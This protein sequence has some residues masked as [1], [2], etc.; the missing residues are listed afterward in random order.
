MRAA[1]FDPKK[2]GHYKRRCHDLIIEIWGDDKKGRAA[3][4]KWFKQTFGKDIHFSQITDE[5][6][7]RRIYER[8]WAY[9]FRASD[10]FY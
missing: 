7:L 4:Y 1:F 5:K 3:T 2:P 6:E 9:S 8:L 10:L